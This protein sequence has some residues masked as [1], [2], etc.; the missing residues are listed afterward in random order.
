MIIRSSLVTGNANVSVPAIK[1]QKAR[2]LTVL[3][4]GL[5]FLIGPLWLLNALSTE[6]QRLAA[7]STLIAGFTGTLYVIGVAR[8]I[9]TLVA[10]SA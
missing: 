7:T 5:L 2:D 6:R 1:M 9:E 8:P 10:A 4:F 3:L